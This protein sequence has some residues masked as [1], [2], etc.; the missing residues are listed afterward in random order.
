MPIVLTKLWEYQTMEMDVNLSKVGAIE[1]V[2]ISG[3]IGGGRGLGVG[4]ISPLSLPAVTGTGS[5]TTA[6]ILQPSSPV[7]KS[8]CCS[9]ISMM[10]MSRN[11]DKVAAGVGTGMIFNNVRKSNHRTP[12]EIYFE[13]RGKSCKKLLKFNGNSNKVSSQ[14]STFFHIKTTHLIIIITICQRILF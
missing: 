12:Q 4:H 8:G 2:G 14:F 5:T 6:T 10:M 13:S 3:M 11:N 9:C 1:L 7:A